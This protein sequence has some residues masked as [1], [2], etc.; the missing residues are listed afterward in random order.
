MTKSSFVKRLEQRMIDLGLKQLQVEQ[1]AGMS[2]G[3]LTRV[4]T[5]ERVKIRLNTSQAL[6]DALG[7]RR[8]WLFDGDG[9][10]LPPGATPPATTTA[11]TEASRTTVELD[12]RYSNLAQAATALRG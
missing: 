9:P 2:R 5:G 12:W 6:A 3:Y 1:A 10:M 8:E 11:Q 7:V 4:L